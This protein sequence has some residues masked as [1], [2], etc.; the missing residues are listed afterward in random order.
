VTGHFVEM[1]FPSGKVVTHVTRTFVPAD[2]RVPIERGNG[3]RTIAPDGTESV[4][5]MPLQLVDQNGGVT[6]LDAGL[7]VF[8]DPPTVR[9]PHPSF[10]VDLAD[11]YCP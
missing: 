11:Y 8:T 10:D 3:T 7:I 1:I 6:L 2:P 5:G 9:G 4:T